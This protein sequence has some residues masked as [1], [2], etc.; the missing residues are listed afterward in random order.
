MPDDYHEDISKDLLGRHDLARTSLSSQHQL[1]HPSR[2]SDL[3][4]LMPS[5]AGSGADLLDQGCQILSKSNTGP[6][7]KMVTRLHALSFSL[8]KS[9]RRSST[10]AWLRCRSQQPASEDKYCISEQV[11]LHRQADRSCS[12]SKMCDSI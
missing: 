7:F 6:R 8:R 1:G 9:T 10:T 12:C 2:I 4:T 5:F 11:R 3:L